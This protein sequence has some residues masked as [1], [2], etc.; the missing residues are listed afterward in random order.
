[1]ILIFERKY[2]KIK[3][4]LMFLIFIVFW[5]LNNS[6]IFFFYSTVEN[7]NYKL[8]P[9]SL[10]SNFTINWTYVFKLL[11]SQ[12]YPRVVF[13]FTIKSSLYSFIIFKLTFIFYFILNGLNYNIICWYLL[14][15]NILKKTKITK[16][17]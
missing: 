4:I 5:R 2:L 10:P 13:N 11:N 8:N 12:S 15:L 17:Y 16:G 6:L 14:R 3:I 1:M 9:Q 7:L